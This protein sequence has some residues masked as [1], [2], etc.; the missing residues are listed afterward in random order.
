MQVSSVI[1]LQKAFKNKTE[2]GCNAT[3][4]LRR[5][6]SGKEIDAFTGR[7]ERASLFKAWWNILSANNLQQKPSCKRETCPLG[8]LIPVNTAACVGLRQRTT[9]PSHGDVGN[10]PPVGRSLQV[11]FTSSPTSLHQCLEMSHGVKSWK[12]LLF[13]EPNEETAQYPRA[14]F[15]LGFPCSGKRLLHDLL[16]FIPLVEQ[17]WQRLSYKTA[18]SALHWRHLFYSQGFRLVWGNKV[19]PASEKQLNWT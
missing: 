13:A 3:A 15:D 10:P 12:A 5:G 9:S 6:E 1:T 4:L 7:K 8:P 19:N 11:T 18:S 2:V 14:S 16:K 17:P